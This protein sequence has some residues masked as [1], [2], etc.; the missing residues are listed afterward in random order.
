MARQ[1]E[2]AP[3]KNLPAMIAHSNF[4]IKQIRIPCTYTMNHNLPSGNPLI[5]DI[6]TK[7]K[8]VEP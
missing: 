4:P 3:I 8:M 7:A 6:S 5:K 2:P 1:H